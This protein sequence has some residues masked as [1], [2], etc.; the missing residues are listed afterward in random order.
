[1]LRWAEQGSVR[2]TLEEA[3]RGFLVI[4]GALGTE[5]ERLG[6]DLSGHLWS[7]RVLLHQPEQIERVHRSYL[8]AGADCITAASYQVS[9]EGFHRENL[10]PEQA[11]TALRDSVILAR[12]VR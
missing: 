6:C 1:M 4:D 9:A 11:E 12:R 3:L 5:L 2:M 7:G 10:P 8:D